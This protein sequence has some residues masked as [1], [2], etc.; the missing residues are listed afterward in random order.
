MFYAQ[1]K[2]Y[3][4]KNGRKYAVEPVY[5][6]DREQCISDSTEWVKKSGKKIPQVLIVKDNENFRKIMTEKTIES[7][8]VNDV[9]FISNKGIRHEK[10]IN[11][12]HFLF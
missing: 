9:L 11:L 2:T 10:S 7:G 4:G 3:Y 12:I 8:Y 5:Y 6:S 1:L